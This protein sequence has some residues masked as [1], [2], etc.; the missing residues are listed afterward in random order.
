LHASIKQTTKTD[1][2]VDPYPYTENLP[3]LHAHSSCLKTQSK[4]QTY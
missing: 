2:Q 3:S 4:V 1:T